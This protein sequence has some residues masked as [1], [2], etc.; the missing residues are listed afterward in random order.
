MITTKIPRATP[1]GF[2]RLE[3]L[4]KNKNEKQQKPQTFRAEYTIV[5]GKNCGMHTKKLM[6]IGATLSL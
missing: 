5:N 4:T 1:E 6:N 2:L 3:I